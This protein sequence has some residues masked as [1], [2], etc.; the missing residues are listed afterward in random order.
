MAGAIQIS[1]ERGVRYLHFGSAYVQGAMRIA[2]PWALELEYT[3]DLMLPLLLRPEPWPAT[4][5]QVGLG[6]GSVAKFLFRHRA[7]ARITAVEISA[8]VLAAARQFFRLPDDAQ[9]LR[10]EIAEGHEY[11]LAKKRAWDFI[12]V[13]GYDDRGRPGM[14][15]TLPF[16]LNC[17]TRLAA[18]GMLA[19]NLLTRRK[20]VEASV[21][22]LRE[23]FEG[24]VLVLP[25]SE[26]GNTVALAATGAPIRESIED[27]REAAASLKAQTGLN[28][29]PA[30]ARLAAATRKGVEL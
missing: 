24:R 1:E 28:L 18:G 27:L 12:V 17:R 16:Y 5:L 21:A 10:V 13:D 15:D 8:E 29:A 6:T 25:P 4:V 7:E 22:R 9:R 3:R 19:A 2:R 26:A 11:L 23:A 20:G 14:L 30:V